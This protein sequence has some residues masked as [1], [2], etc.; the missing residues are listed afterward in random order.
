TEVDKRYN[1]DTHGHTFPDG[2]PNLRHFVSHEFETYIQDSWRGKSNL[3]GDYGPRWTLLQ[4]PYEK[5]GVQVAPTISLDNWFKQR[6]Q[7]MAHG[8]PFND[9]I[10]FDLSGQANGKKP[11]WD[12]DYKDFAP[13]L[14]IAYS[15]NLGGPGKTSIRAGVGMFYDHFGE[16]TVNT[17][18]R[19]GSFGLST[20]LTNPGGQQTVDTAPR[21]TTNGLYTLPPQLVTPCGAQCGTFPIQFPPSNFAT[22]WGLDDKLRTPYSYVFNLSFERELPQNFVISLSYVGRQGRRLLQEEDLAQPRDVYDPQSQMDYYRA[23][24][25]LDNAVLAGTLESDLAPIPYWEN[26]FGATSA[27]AG[28][29]SNCASGIPGSPTATQNLYDLL[30][31]GLVHNETTFQQIFDGAGGADCFPGCAT[32][33]GVTGPGS[34]LAPQF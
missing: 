33:G 19:R 10:T 27:G 16:A 25:L 3:T 32:L 23:T 28:G 26:L 34:Y 7:T 29:E 24:R 18:D 15:P 5:N 6:G 31:C 9:L 17:F 30:S 22:Q 20:L 11:Y 12:Y 8:L 4:P 1:F 14:S 21:M 2:A 13:R